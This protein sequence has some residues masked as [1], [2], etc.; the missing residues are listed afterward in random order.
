MTGQH[1]FQPCAAQLHLGLLLG[2]LR[3]GQQGDRLLTAVEHRLVARGL[4]RQG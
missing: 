4:A 3:K 1:R 2:L